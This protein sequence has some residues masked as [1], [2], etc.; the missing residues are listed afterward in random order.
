MSQ[1]FSVKRWPQ[2]LALEE[3]MLRKVSFWIQMKGVRLHLSTE[4]NTRKL[5]S[6]LGK[7]IEIEDLSLARG[8][9]RA[10]VLM[11]TDHPLISGC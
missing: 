11:D 2:Q 7:V 1:N 3:V 10:R 5:A 6:H 8:F 4:V 9:L